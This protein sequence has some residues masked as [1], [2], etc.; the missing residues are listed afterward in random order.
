MPYSTHAQLTASIG[1]QELI[2]LSDRSER[3]DPENAGTEDWT[4]IDAAA[5]NAD[6]R[7][8]RYITA[9][10]PLVNVPADFVQIHCDITRYFLYNDQP[11]PHVQKQ[12]DDALAYLEKVAAGKIP[13]GPDL[14]GT[15]DDKT[16]DD[17]AYNAND[18]IFSSTNLS[19]F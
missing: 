19:S 11:T 13:I 5:A 10:L 17:V 6:A 9:Y 14:T 4:V 3:T 7:I 2:Q 12:Y 8:D 15:V 18:T 1:K 16:N